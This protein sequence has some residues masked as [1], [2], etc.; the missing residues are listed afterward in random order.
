MFGLVSITITV[1]LLAQRGYALSLT[2]TSVDVTRRNVLFSP[3]LAFIPAV[4]CASPLVASASQSVKADMI[5]ELQT[6]RDKLA[7]IPQLLEEKEWEKVRNILKT[8]PVNKLWNLGESQNTLFNLAKDSG[9]I[10]LL[11]LKDELSLSLQ[12]CDQFTYDNAFVYYQPGIII[13]FLYLNNLRSIYQS[14]LLL[15][16]SFSTQEMVN[17]TSKSHK[18]LQRKR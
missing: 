17:S 18:S 10:E 16:S 9:D 6:S 3:C 5:A 1:V 12:M 14:S 13:T 11:E 15:Y 8:P 2:Q 4:F 7:P